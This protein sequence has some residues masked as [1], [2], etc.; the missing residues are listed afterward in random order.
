MS[1]QDVTKNIDDTVFYFT[2]AELKERFVQ[3]SKYDKLKA[4]YNQTRLSEYKDISI[5]RQLF[6]WEDWDG[7]AE[8]TVYY[9]CVLKVDIGPY[10]TGTRIETIVM[11]YASSAIHL[12]EGDVQFDKDG[13]SIP[14]YT[15]RIALSIV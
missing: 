15:G 7:S 2:G 5:E 14:S 11:E 6:D 1:T 9:K 8:E 10:K 4:K 3:R 12:H 13:N